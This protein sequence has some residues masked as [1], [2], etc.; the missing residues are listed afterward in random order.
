MPRGPPPP[1]QSVAS[2]PKVVAAAAAS[3][4]SGFR[5]GRAK[6]SAMGSARS[7]NGEAI[8]WW[9][10]AVHDHTSFGL[11]HRC[12][13]RLLNKT[14]LCA[15]QGVVESLGFLLHS[16]AAVPATLPGHG[17]GASAFFFFFFFFF[18][19]HAGARA[20]ARRPRALLPPPPPLV[21]VWRGGRRQQ[22][23]PPRRA[24]AR[25]PPPPDEGGGGRA[26]RHA[27]TSLRRDRRY[28]CAIMARS[29]PGN[30]PFGRGPR[31][32]RPALR[33]EQAT[34]AGRPR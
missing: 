26:L 30:Q 8:Q 6:L 25:A 16:A 20:R 33:A 31:P 19:P 1:A 29:G 32:K 17:G 24:R 2:A 11:S 34:S 27:M 15:A 22:P 3:K 12:S 4:S 21:C 28:S 18:F 13:H 7:L 10:R 23:A 14:P 5:G 9:Y